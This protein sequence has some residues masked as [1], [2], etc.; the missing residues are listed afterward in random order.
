MSLE[1]IVTSKMSITYKPSW[2]W[3]AKTYM[4]KAMDYERSL[5]KSRD[6]EDYSCTNFESQWVIL[7]SDCNGDLVY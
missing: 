3:K 1:Y 4:G 6:G 5:S 7:I 2:G